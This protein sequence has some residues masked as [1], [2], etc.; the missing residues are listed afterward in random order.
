[1]LTRKDQWM[2]IAALMLT[3][4][5]LSDSLI[6][7]ATESGTVIGNG[8]SEALEQYNVNDDEIWALINKEELRSLIDVEALKKNINTEALKT[9]IDKNALS[10]GISDINLLESMDAEAILADYNE[11]KKSGELDVMIKDIVE[12]EDFDEDFIK[13]HPVDVPNVKV[14][15][16]GNVSPL[17]YI[18]DPLQL[19]YQTEAAK[20]G[21]GRVKENA[22]VLF[23]NTDGDYLFSDTSDKLKIVNMSNVPLQVTISA[24]IG[25]NENIKVVDSKSMLTGETPSLFMALV[26]D[27]DI[28]SIMNDQGKTEITIVLKPVPDG[29]YKYTLNEETGKYESEMSADADESRFDS[30]EFG[31]MGECNTDANWSEVGEL[32]KIS[33]SWKTEPILTDWDKVNEELEAA[34]KVKFDAYKK[35]KLAKLRE[36]ELNKRVEIALEEL[37]TE[38][39]SVLIDQEI[40]RLAKEKF[41]ELKAAAL[42]GELTFDGSTLKENTNDVL[43]IGENNVEAINN[44]DNSVNADSEAAS[45]EKDEN[46]SKNEDSAGKSKNTEDKETVVSERI[47]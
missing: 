36:E 11:K 46:E 29:T 21:G 37:I 31:V 16:I 25:S 3:L 39:L 2:G 13:N 8:S 6:V 17:D 38:E 10:K 20:Y 42:R 12:A 15:I 14:P 40:E 44:A 32:P 30:F 47:Q 9:K 24:S 41:E 1:M 23:K 26:G 45:T 7:Q 4:F 22:S 28:L 5:I 35:V 34:D 18:L 27:E 33:V 19:I 43:N